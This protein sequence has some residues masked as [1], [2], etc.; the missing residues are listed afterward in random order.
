MNN[1]NL[2]EVLH[3]DYYNYQKPI[4]ELFWLNFICESAIK[5]GS[6]E[7]LQSLL[8]EK[9]SNLAVET[10]N[11]YLDL[12]LPMTREN[13]QREINKLY[14]QQQFDTYIAPHLTRRMLKSNNKE[15]HMVI[16]D[17]LSRT[18]KNKSNILNKYQS[19]DNYFFWHIVYILCLMVRSM[20]SIY[21]LNFYKLISSNEKPVNYIEQDSEVMALTTM[22]IVFGM[23]AAFTFTNFSIALIVK[24]LYG[25]DIDI[26]SSIDD[27]FLRHYQHYLLSNILNSVNKCHHELEL[28]TYD[29]IQQRTSACFRMMFNHHKSDYTKKH[30]VDIDSAPSLIESRATYIC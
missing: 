1:Y 28:T 24:N 4:R 6:R 2:N 9:P 23:Y 29:K 27:I 8:Q 15:N 13:Y 7:W 3:C 25:N 26:T 22:G 21:N 5:N 12:S 11:K 20:L 17:I 14:R 16:L 19:F 30:I 10:I 18:D